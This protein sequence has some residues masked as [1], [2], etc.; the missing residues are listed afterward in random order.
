MPKDDRQATLP[1]PSPGE[2][3]QQAKEPHIYGV[4]ELVQLASRRLEQTFPDIWVEG[5]VSNLR[6]P[7]SGH[8]YLTLKDA[9]AQLSVVV[10]RST[11]R[12]IRFELEDGQLLRM[13]GRLAIYG[14]QGRFQL[15]A[16][17][18]EPAGVGALQLAMEQLK[19]KL[20][21]EGLFAAQRKKPLP[22]LPRRV[23][24]V[25]SPT[26]AAVRD[27]LR[28][29]EHRFPLSVLVCPSAVQGRDAPAEL[30]RALARADALGVDLI[31]LTRGGGSLEDLQAFNDEQVARQIARCLTPVVSAVGHEI[32]ITIS[33]LVA[34][35][36]APT[37][38]A[39]AELVAPTLVEV[40]ERLERERLRL[41][42]GVSHV[43]QRHALALERARGR[44]G[45]PR[46]RIDRG[47]QLLDEL[48][49]RA[50][51]GARHGLRQR[52]EKL[53]A[54]R[55]RLET[56]RPSAR[57]ARD[58]ALLGEWKNRLEQNIIEQLTRRRALLGETAATL[59]ALSPLAVLARGYSVLRNEAGRVVANAGEVEVGEILDVRLHR[60]SLGCRVEERDLSN[61]PD[62]EQ[63]PILDP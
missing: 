9:R 38:T 53:A 47:R 28:V 30:T 26:G 44:L 50:Q 59:H 37:P 36:R 35:G 25:T 22:P 17:R 49:V 45:A 63:D 39:A 61:M 8:V 27:I 6:S 43:L 54:L 18:V 20:E 12:R 1:L 7:S 14:P 40:E 29:L 34:D 3:A 41:Q 57:L 16:E 32:D 13:A 52:R 62:P 48:L 21:A 31:I 10:F 23:A 11:M 46:A 15:T 33:D 60:G 58:R 51:L 55:L 24:L 19:R 2:A 4:G 56:G 5:E 42:R